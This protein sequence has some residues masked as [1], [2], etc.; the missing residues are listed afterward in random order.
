MLYNV[1]F[2]LADMSTHLVPY[3]PYSAAD[4][5]DRKTKRVCF[6]DS[7]EHCISAIGSCNRNLYTGC[8]IV[9]RS[10][11]ENSLDQSRIISSQELYDTHKVPD[12]LENNECWYLDEVDVT[13]E[14]YTICNF[15]FEYDIAFT[16]IKREDLADLI[17]KYNP[18]SPMK[19]KESIEYAYNRTVGEL[20][21]KERYDD[22]DA[23]ED[24]VAG[25]PWA[26]RIKI[27]NL[28]MKKI[29][30]EMEVSLRDLKMKEMNNM[31]EVSL[32][33]L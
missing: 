6:A 22:S 2:D 20:Q 24:K 23:F 21:K 4:D 16:C 7:I 29:N 25:L 11:D 13:R 28:K 31:M 8:M 27:S 3:I 30:D 12:A 14:I 32:C 15:I 18:D 5:E 17:Y 9:V 26:Q 1:T 19:I 10:V 33:M